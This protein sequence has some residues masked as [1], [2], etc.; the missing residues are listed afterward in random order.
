MTKSNNSASIE[1][2]ADAYADSFSADENYLFPRGEHPDTRSNSEFLRDLE[3]KLFVNRVEKRSRPQKI[4]VIR[5][6]YHKKGP[7]KCINTGDIYKSA[8]EAEVKLSITQ[9][10]VSKVLSGDRKSVHGLNFIY[11]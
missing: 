1:E 11:L 10:F 8:K 6:R 7:I 2:A 4:E 3:N 5:R 9:G